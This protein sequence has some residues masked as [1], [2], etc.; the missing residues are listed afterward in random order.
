MLQ[1]YGRLCTGFLC[2]HGWP[3]SLKVAVAATSSRLRIRRFGY[4]PTMTYW[5]KIWVFSM[6]P[7]G[8]QQLTGLAGLCGAVKSLF[9]P[10]EWAF[11]GMAEG[12]RLDLP[13]GHI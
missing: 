7:L 12:R 2:S 3:S 1:G 9:V 4:G 13:E 8:K 11:A 5:R 6:S 10:Q